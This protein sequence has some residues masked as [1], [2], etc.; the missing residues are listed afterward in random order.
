M[1]SPWSRC[2]QASSCCSGARCRFVCPP[3]GSLTCSVPRPPVGA[4]SASDCWSQGCAPA[5][6]VI[7]WNPHLSDSTASPTS[8]GHT[9]ARSHAPPSNQG[10]QKICWESKGEMPGLHAQ[11]T[12]SPRAEL[13]AQH[14]LCNG[15]VGF[16]NPLS[17]GTWH[18]FRYPQPQHRC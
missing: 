12:P 7:R 17:P 8:P 9:S 16:C 13:H 3:A 10:R 5:P 18:T 11:G 15:Q 4:H 2:L 1:A 14:P 6:P